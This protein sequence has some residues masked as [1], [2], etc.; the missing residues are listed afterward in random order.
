M[1]LQLFLDWKEGTMRRNQF[2]PI[3][4]RVGQR[5]RQ[6]RMLAGLSQMKLGSLEGITFQ[7]IQKYERGAN[8]MSVSRVVRI[9]DVPVTWFLDDLSGENIREI[10]H[11]SED[12]HCR[13]ETLDLVRAYYSIASPEQRRVLGRLLKSLAENHEATEVA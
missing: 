10:S 11:I 3:D 12:G 4:I 9:L 6:Y 5:L 1:S 2:D 13:R 7:Q 8:R